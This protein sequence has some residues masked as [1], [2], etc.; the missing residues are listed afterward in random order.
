MS[1]YACEV[2][3]GIVGSESNPAPN[4]PVLIPQRVIPCGD[5]QTLRFAR[6]TVLFYDEHVIDLSHRVCALYR[7]G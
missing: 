3:E 6:S 2:A 7:M 5:E 4:N 1:A